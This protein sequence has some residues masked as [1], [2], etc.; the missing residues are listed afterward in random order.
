MPTDI[1]EIITR[2]REHHSFDISDIETEDDV[3]EKI[4]NLSRKSTSRIKAEH[5]EIMNKNLLRIS[6]RLFEHEDV[7]EAVESNIRRKIE[8]AEGLEDVRAVPVNLPEYSS[9]L[10]E[11]LETVKRVE[12]SKRARSGKVQ[13]RA[14]FFLNEIDR[15][16]IEKSNFRQVSAVSRFY[17]VSEDEARSKLLEFGYEVDEEG[18]I[19]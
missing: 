19:L 1:D 17:N 10:R 4:N 13:E 11:R 16:L 14:K 2:L 5:A 6:D 7:Q 18:R 3:R 12:A 9:N 15:D 8:E